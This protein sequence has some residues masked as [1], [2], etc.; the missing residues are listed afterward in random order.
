M[1]DTA[2][3]PHLQIECDANPIIFMAIRLS[4]AFLSGLEP[5]P[6]NAFGTPQSV[7]LTSQRLELRP[8][9][10]ISISSRSHQHGTLPNRVQ[11]ACF[12]TFERFGSDID[13]RPVENA[14]VLLWR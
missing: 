8:I 12:G 4:I 5:H 14:S 1:P 2:S 9:P 6:R 10:A 11:N 3:P 13:D 7:A